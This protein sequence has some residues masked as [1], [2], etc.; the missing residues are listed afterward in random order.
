MSINPNYTEEEVWELLIKYLCD[1]HHADIH[2]ITKFKYIDQQNNDD[3]TFYS[4]DPFDES[5]RNKVILRCYANDHFNISGEVIHIIDDSFSEKFTLKGICKKIGAPFPSKTNTSHGVA[6]HS[7]EQEDQ[8]T[9]LENLFRVFEYDR[10]LNLVHAEKFALFINSISHNTNLR[11]LHP[12][13]PTKEDFARWLN[14]DDDLKTYIDLIDLI[15]FDLIISP[16]YRSK[17]YAIAPLLD[18]HYMA[19]SAIVITP[20]GPLFSHRSK[21][22]IA[23]NRNIQD[24]S[25]NNIITIDLES[26]RLLHKSLALNESNIFCGL[27]LDNT[28]Q[29]ASKVIQS[30]CKTTLL[31][32]DIYARPQIATINKIFDFLFLNQSELFSFLILSHKIEHRFLIQSDEEYYTLHHSFLHA[33]IDAAIDMFFQAV[34]QSTLDKETGINNLSA[35]SNH[36]FRAMELSHLSIGKTKVERST[37]RIESKSANTTTTHYENMSQSLESW[38]LESNQSDE[39]IRYK[40]FQSQHF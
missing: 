37:E 40:E 1:F 16:H 32:P 23:L 8:I 2:S 26:G 15:N 4:I 31:L 21:G 30:G 7:N 14:R 17:L 13:A 18:N 28:L 12:L 5:A 36:H 22:L 3:S 11:T 39:M 33:G 38:L 24:E 6:M 27:T 19:L 34:D 20:Q 25:V 9:E 35:F 29:M 10:A